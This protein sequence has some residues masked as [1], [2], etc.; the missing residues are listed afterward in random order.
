[1]YNI[2]QENYNMYVYTASKITQYTCVLK[3]TWKVTSKVLT[4]VYSKVEAITDLIYFLWLCKK[5]RNCNKN[6]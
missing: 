1:M 4:V 5:H 2:T 6:I 3:R